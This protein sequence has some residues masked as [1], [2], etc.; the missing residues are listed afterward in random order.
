LVLQRYAGIDSKFV[1]QY[2]RQFMDDWKVVREEGIP[3]QVFDVLFVSYML[4]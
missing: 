4:S 1:D 2:H 3:I